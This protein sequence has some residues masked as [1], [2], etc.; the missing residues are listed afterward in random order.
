MGKDYESFLPEEDEEA[1]AER[2]EALRDALFEEKVARW[3]EK[4]E[5]DK[6]L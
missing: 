6:D 2:E 5:M 4:H 1:R 3:A